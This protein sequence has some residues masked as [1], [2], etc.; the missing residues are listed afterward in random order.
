VLNVDNDSLLSTRKPCRDLIVKSRDGFV[1]ATAK[2][3]FVDVVG[4]FLRRFVSQ[5]RSDLEPLE[6]HLLPFFF[7]RRKRRLA[8][9]FKVTFGGMAIEL[10]RHP[11]M[12]CE[13]R[14]DVQRPRAAKP[15]GLLFDAFAT[16]RVSPAQQHEETGGAS[17]SDV[18]Y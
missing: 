14:E 17:T 8:E 16:C 11:T 7:S 9:G 3:S 5:G 6:D 1:S 12:V 10:F 2:G 4:H 15:S 13:A 18:G